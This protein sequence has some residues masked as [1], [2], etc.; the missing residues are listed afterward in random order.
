[1]LKKISESPIVVLGG[2]IISVISLAVSII[3][4]NLILKWFVVVFLIIY[5]IILTI[6]IIVRFFS[7]KALIN[8]LQSEYYSK[9]NHLL[10]DIRRFS[11]KVVEATIRISKS[12]TSIP[13]RTFSLSVKEICNEIKELTHT[14]AGEQFSIC[15]KSI[16]TG[17]DPLMNQDID[18]WKTKT[19]IRVG[20]DE[21]ERNKKD[22]I[23]QKVC[24]NTSFY[25][26]IKDTLTVWVS[27]NLAE[28]EKAFKLINKVY[29]N[30]NQHYKYK[31]TIVAPICIKSNL[32]S[33]S[34]IDMAN[35]SAQ[36]SY[37]Y[38]GFLCIDSPKCFD[39]EKQVFE[40]L[41][42]LLKILAGM[43]YP[44]FEAKLINEIN[45][46]TP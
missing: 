28:T 39:N 21:L 18:E 41:A 20:T 25:D 10:L 27:P 24:D 45:G 46:I 22:N 9:E 36:N 19:I 12:K 16:L 11:E 8:N 17:P 31:S 32:V 42:E 30:P 5:I 13:E 44:L 43:L 3:S 26:I 34:I 23:Q 1:M 29:N 2:F 40:D 7:K 38:M 6:V 33:Q 4:G 37:H 15:I 14:L 35:E